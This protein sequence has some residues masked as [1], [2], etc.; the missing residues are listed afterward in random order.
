MIGPRQTSL[1]S[2]C[3]AKGVS[4]RFGAIR[5]MGVENGGNPQGRRLTT[6]KEIATFLGR[7]ERT[8][9]RWE[10]SR[11]LP[12]RRVPGSGRASV[13]AYA[14]ELQAW[15]DGTQP[16][17]PAA[18]ATPP[19]KAKFAAVVIAVA[20]LALVAGGVVWFWS[21]P[22]PE[23]VRDPAA[24]AF[25]KSGLHEWQTRTPSGLV[26]AVKDFDAAIA[27]D[28]GYAQAYEGLADTY[29]LMREY[30]LM[31]PDEAY[32]KAREA[33]THAIAL[34]PA[35][36]GAHA[37]LAFV[38][39]YWL[40]KPADARREFVR[41]IALDPKNAGA[42]HWYATFLMTVGEPEA[43]TREIDKAAELDSESSAILAD[44]GL[45]L[46]YGG[47]TNEAVALLAQLEADQPGFASPPFYLSVIDL[48]RGDDQGHLRETERH[49]AV[50]HD[51]G[52]A[53]LAASGA[54]GL[55]Q[56]GRAGMLSAELSMRLEAYAKGKGQAY[57]LA[58]TYALLG[59]RAQALSYLAASVSR[60]E[61][62]SIALKIDPALD[63]L[64][65]EPEFAKLL[66]AT[67]F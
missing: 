48:V 34:D 9:K 44:K 60:R 47:R 57:W 38:D 33:A 54:K 19:A 45:I 26:R 52:E 37:A 58:Q 61:P 27:R 21:R 64:R 63:S 59:E 8:V 13:F 5:D 46:Y 39:F 17:A 10:A 25:Y 66:K 16:D 6:W 3:G 28:P 20:A 55:A 50:M 23:P 29:N 15:L 41:A 42:H 67:G 53:A 14:H 24:V 22:A 49:A 36:A 56:G 31:P 62:E 30:T 4:G 11:G 65:R 18:V 35:L 1:Y 32:A 7:D 2:R 51:A 40:R 43:A 12:V